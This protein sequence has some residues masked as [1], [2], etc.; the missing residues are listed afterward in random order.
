MPSQGVND[1]YGTPEQIQN[2]AFRQVR[3][4]VLHILS[5]NGLEWADLPPIRQQLLNR[6]CVW[7]GIAVTRALFPGWNWGSNTR[8]IAKRYNQKIVDSDLG[9]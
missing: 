4:A 6:V 7:F 9:E 2:E 8:E 1:Q 3:L 5:F